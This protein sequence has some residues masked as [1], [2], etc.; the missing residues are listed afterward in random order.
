MKDTNNH[1][2]PAPIPLAGNDIRRISCRAFGRATRQHQRKVEMAETLWQAAE[3]HPVH[4]TFM[5]RS[6]GVKMPAYLAAKYP[7]EMTIVLQ[8]EFGQ[9]ERE[10][11]PL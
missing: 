2:N 5:T 9:A 11:R 1:E 3:D 8:Y 7:D 6:E 10:G 4:I